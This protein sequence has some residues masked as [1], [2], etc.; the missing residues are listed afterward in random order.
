LVHHPEI[1]AGDSKAFT[2]ELF[3]VYAIP[4]GDFT[5]KVTGVLMLALVVLGTAEGTYTS[6]KYPSNSPWIVTAT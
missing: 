2:A 3:D 6:A 4:F 1:S 5:D